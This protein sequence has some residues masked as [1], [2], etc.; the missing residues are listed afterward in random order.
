MKIYYDT[1][2]INHSCGMAVSEK[3]C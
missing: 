2:E 3:W 1:M